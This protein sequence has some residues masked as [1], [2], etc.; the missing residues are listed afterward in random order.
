MA[1]RIRKLTGKFTQ[2]EKRRKFHSYLDNLRSLCVIG[3]TVETCVDAYEFELDQSQRKSSRVHTSG[4]P[5]ETQV[6]RKLKTC[7]DL[8]VRLVGA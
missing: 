7:V 8:R 2:V 1:K 5:N 3:Q 4:W 6:E